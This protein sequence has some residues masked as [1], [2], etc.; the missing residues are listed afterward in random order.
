MARSPASVCNE[1]CLDEDFSCPCFVSSYSKTTA[2]QF[3]GIM[4]KF[5]L[6]S[7]LSMYL[8][9]FVVISEYVTYATADVKEFLVCD[10]EH[11]SW[12]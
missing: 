6:M 9:Y 8:Y 7:S 1:D 3:N 10:A 4:T 11:C 12:R 2:R 5:L